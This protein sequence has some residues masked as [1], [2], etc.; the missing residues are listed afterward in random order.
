MTGYLI[1]TVPGE[2][3]GKARPRFHRKPVQMGLGRVSY[4][5]TPKDTEKYEQ[6]IGWQAKV[7][8]LAANMPLL[9]GAVALYVEAHF[10]MPQKMSAKARKRAL[11]HE[12][13]P[14]KK[15]DYDNIAKI[16]TD[17]LKNIA[18][19]DDSQVVFAR[20]SK[21]WSLMPRLVVALEPLEGEANARIVPTLPG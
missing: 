10:G 21:F 8:M 17:G 15:P 16:V 2:P 6:A 14:A 9:T 4:A 3:V 7:A 19:K 1:F 20:I 12:I 11:A 5:Y 13:Y 18:M